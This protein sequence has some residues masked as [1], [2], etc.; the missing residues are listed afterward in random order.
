MYKT[1][2]NLCTNNVSIFST[3]L[4]DDR[5]QLFLHSACILQ[6][7]QLWLSSALWHLMWERRRDIHLTALKI[8]EDWYSRKLCIC[9]LYRKLPFNGALNPGLGLTGG[10]MVSQSHWVYTALPIFKSPWQPKVD[11]LESGG[12][13][14]VKHSHYG[15]ASTSLKLRSAFSSE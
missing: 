8:Q 7:E 11:D 13:F 5:S 10:K 12:W 9:R 4:D 2:T 15:N 3:C 14:Q 6:T 1:G